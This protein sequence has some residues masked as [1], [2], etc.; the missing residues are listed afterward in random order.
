M[1][2][3]FSLEISIVWSICFFSGFAWVGWGLDFFDWG[4]LRINLLPIEDG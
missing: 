4:L 2:R 3:F 1:M